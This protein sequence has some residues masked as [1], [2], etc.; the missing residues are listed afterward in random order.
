MK[1]ILLIAILALCYVNANAQDIIKTKD[2]TEVLSKVI[3]ID[4]TSVKYKKWGNLSGPT[5]TISISRISS[6]TYQNGTVDTFAN[7]VAETSD[8]AQSIDIAG[9]KVSTSVQTSG[10]NIS[11]SVGNVARQ[12]DLYAKAR[13]LKT[14]GF[15]LGGL[16]FA[17]CL[18]WGIAQISV[19]DEF[20]LAPV[21][22]GSIGST[23]ITAAFVL[24][25]YELE[26][27]A[28]SLSCYNLVEYEINDNIALNAK[29]FRYN[30]TNTSFYGVGVSMKF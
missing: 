23:A 15:V 20:P 17:G 22:I 26:A 25:T 2:N 4:D 24:P 13:A 5:Y 27:E 28:A 29:G 1:K 7:Y 16:T 8:I 18:V 9:E 12:Q 6:I 11:R 10:N 19:S 30:P 21:L 14:C 3:E